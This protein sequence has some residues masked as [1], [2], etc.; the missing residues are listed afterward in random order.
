MFRTSLLATAAAVFLAVPALAGDIT[1]KDPYAIASTAMSKSGAAFMT[2]ENAG[3]SDDRLVGVASDIAERVELHTHIADANG[4]M[5]MV[6]VKEGFPVPAH[7][8][9][10]LQRGSDHVMFLGLKQPL[11]DG[12]TVH[13]VLTFE[14]AG[15][16]PVDI[17]VDLKRVPAASAPAAGQ[18]N[19]NGMDHGAM[20]GMNMSN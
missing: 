5:K 8:E 13:V 18:M 19:M 9:H 4:V 2:I 15:E 10:V 11:N 7:G 3:A 14:K 17:P 12:D 16:V 6:E 1:I 20:P